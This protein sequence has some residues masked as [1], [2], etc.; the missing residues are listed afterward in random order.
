MFD[1]LEVDRLEAI[2]SSKSE[3]TPFVGPL[4]MIVRE[5]ETPRVSRRLDYLEATDSW[6]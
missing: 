1:T 2:R 5:R 3:L 4:L 6:V